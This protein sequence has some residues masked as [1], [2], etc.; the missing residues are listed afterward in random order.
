[1]PGIHKGE[2]PLRRALQQA[3]VLRE[4]T[5]SPA[6]CTGDQACLPGAGGKKYCFCKPG[7]RLVGAGHCRQVHGRDLHLIQ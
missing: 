1:M 7:E 5:A 3:G 4:C 6:A 2:A